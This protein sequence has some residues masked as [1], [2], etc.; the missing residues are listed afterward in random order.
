ML[1]KPH[2]DDV[3]R[4]SITD[5]CLTIATFLQFEFQS[6]NIEFTQHIPSDDYYIYADENQIKQ[7]LLNILR[8]SIEAVNINGT[9]ALSLYATNAHSVTIELCDNG[10]GMDEETLAQIFEPFFT[11]KESGT[12]LGMVLTHEIIRSFGGDIS[13]ESTPEVGTRI[14]ISFPVMNTL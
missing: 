6:K 4:L 2:I 7:V 1:S 9:I 10:I 12:G 11:T 3:K 13:I 8:N 5:V 14:A